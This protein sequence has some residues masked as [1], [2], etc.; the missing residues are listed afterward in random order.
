MT[1]NVSRAVG[2]HQLNFGLDYRILRPEAGP[3]SYQAE[4]EYTSLA[5]VLASNAALAYIISRQPV[6]L[7]FSNWSLFAQDTWKATRTLTIT[8]GLR[9]EYDASPSSPNGTLPF[10]VT[11]VNDLATMTL[12]PPGTPLWHPQKDD[13]APR[14]GVAWQLLPDV[15][16][17]AGAGFFYDLG[18]A[19]V[20]NGTSAF[21]YAQDKLFLGTGFPVSA[22]DAAPPPFTT[23]PPV[24]YLAVVDPNHVLPRTYEWNA[25]LERRFGRAT[26]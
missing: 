25:A 1:D 15:V 5:N 3:V 9:W 12:A 23:T 2:A 4:Y 14:L 6:T 11:Q 13:F 7:S 17:R 8:Y 21:P 26:F 22:A 16:F 20:A 24:S 19:G 18:Y 10:T